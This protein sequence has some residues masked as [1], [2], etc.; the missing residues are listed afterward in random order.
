MEFGK[1]YVGISVVFACHDGN[2]KFLFAKR[3]KG[4]R[5]G[6][7]LWEISAGGLECGETITEGLH[8]ELLEEFCVRPKKVEFI[9]YKETILRENDGTFIKHWISFEHLVEVDSNEVR[10]GEPDKC[11]AIEWRSI[12]DMPGKLSHGSESTIDNVIAYLA[13]KK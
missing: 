2:G 3:G 1:D 7:G 8:R 12:D 11:E 5:D 9:G 10:I 4:A 6:H 13:K